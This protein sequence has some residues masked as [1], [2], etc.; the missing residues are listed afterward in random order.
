MRCMGAE[1][2]EMD[3]SDSFL[4]FF[5]SHRDLNSAVEKQRYILYRT[6]VSL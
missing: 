1:K 4:R 2:E 6:V 3:D 5:S